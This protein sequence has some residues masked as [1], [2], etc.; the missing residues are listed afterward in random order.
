VG[1]L[2][3][4]LFGTCSDPQAQAPDDPLRSPGDLGWVGTQGLGDRFAGFAI[5]QH[6]Q[7]REVRVV[8]SG[9]GS[10]IGVARYRGHDG[11]PD[12]DQ[13]DRGQQCG[14][15]LGL[16]HDSVRLGGLG[17][18]REGSA[19]V[20]GVDEYRRRAPAAL[21][22]PAVCKPVAPRGRSRALW[23]SELAPSLGW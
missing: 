4:L 2:S 19:V 14:Y 20:G 17:G 9:D 15:R 5:E 3:G 16:V 8:D 22:A 18:Q 12:G 10:L 7:D 1:T 11:L 6:R 21:D 13:A 23:S